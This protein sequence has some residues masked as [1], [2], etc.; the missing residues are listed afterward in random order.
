MEYKERARMFAKD[1]LGSI[2]CYKGKEYLI[3]VVE[4]YPYDEE[5]DD[6]GKDISYVNRGGNGNGKRI[7]TGKDK[8]GKVFTYSAMFHVVGECETNDNTGR[9]DNALIRGAIK[10]ENG[11]PVYED[12]EMSFNK[13]KPDKLCRAILNKQ[14]G[15]IFK[16]YGERDE[17]QIKK[18]RNYRIT[19]ENIVKA[20]RI[21]IRKAENNDM[22]FYLSQ[23]FFK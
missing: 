16:V 9:C 22:R 18:S 14:S 4:I 6:T 21:G 11:K 23:D 10:I 7:L 20:D 12:V 15:I 13:G 17:V 8:Q 1:L 3:T 19:D 5:A 2:I